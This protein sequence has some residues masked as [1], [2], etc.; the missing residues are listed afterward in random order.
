MSKLRAAVIGLG[1]GEE[2]IAGYEAHPDCEVVAICDLSA[3]RLA[4]VGE[5]HP[6][7]RRTDR[8]DELLRDPEVDVVSVASYDDAHFEQ[9][10]TAL[11]HGKHVFVEKPLCLHESEAEQI[12]A[13]LREHSGLRLSSNLPLRA[14]PR[15]VLLR[16][17]IERGEL[18]DIYYL[19]GDYDY[20]RLQKITE[21]WR[22][23]LDYYSVVLGGAV[24]MVDLLLWLTGDRVKRA[25][26]AGNQIASRGTKF[27]FP[28]LV[29]GT[30]E[31][32]GGAIAKVSANFGCVH[33]HFHGVKV[34]GTEGTFI[35]GL[36]Q[37][38]VWKRVDGAPESTAIDLPYPGITKSDLIPSFVDS[39]VGNGPAR[40]SAEEVLATMAACFAMER[41][42]E[43]RAPV[44]VKG[45][46]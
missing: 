12:H 4:E 46:V 15:F 7:L 23:D 22:G 40:V 1:V 44:E 18:G 27:R 8:P 2:H 29:V 32:E 26:A 41:A 13:L 30:L 33:P 5:R 21:G 37:A 3:E 35:N 11:E 36:D 20:G 10:K 14:S 16:E 28:D 45:F 17:M 25:T 19:E 43:D 31:L 38:T 9:V 24:H 39:I 34:F 6:E 42:L